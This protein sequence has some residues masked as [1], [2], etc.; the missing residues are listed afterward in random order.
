[1]LMA[2]PTYLSFDP[3]AEINGETIR[4]MLAAFQLPRHGEN[5]MRKHG[6]PAEPV[7]GGWYPMQAWLNVLGEL[8]T[9]YGEQTVYAA[10]LQV[11]HHS[12]W[13]PTVH[14][15]A[16]A[17]QMLEAVRQANMRGHSIGYYTVEQQG[18]RTVRVVCSNP[19]PASFDHGLLT[20]LARK[21]K[22]A[23]AMRVRV[24]KEETPAHSPVTLKWFSVSW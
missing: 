4:V 20:G 21:F 8:E 22:P 1:M 13:P 10:G 2:S 15:L 12:L 5:I 11:V 24:T 19:S 9:V 16:E 6:L 23:E 17:L 3:Q 14:T 7:L 18:P